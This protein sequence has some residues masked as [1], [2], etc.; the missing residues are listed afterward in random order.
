MALAHQ[1]AVTASPVWLFWAQVQY[2][3]VKRREQLCGGEHRGVVAGLGDLD[4]ADGF[5]ADEFRP[6]AQVG[7]GLGARHEIAGFPGLEGFT[8]CSHLYLQMQA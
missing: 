8:G 6:V 5:Q 3:V 1:E 7:D 4:Q 2:V